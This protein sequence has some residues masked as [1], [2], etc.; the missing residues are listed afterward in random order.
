MPGRHGS[1]SLIGMADMTENQKSPVPIH[2]AILRAAARRMGEGGGFVLLALLMGGAIVLVGSHQSLL[3]MLV[4]V[5]IVTACSLAVLAR[6]QDAQGQ[7]AMKRLM[8][9]AAQTNEELQLRRRF[10]LRDDSDAD[11]VRKDFAVR[12][13]AWHSDA[14]TGGVDMDEVKTARNRLFHLVSARGSAA[15]GAE[16]IAEWSKAAGPLG[17]AWGALLPSDRL[18][19]ASER[20]G[21]ELRPSKTSQGLRVQA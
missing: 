13:K 15:T 8:A 3:S 7:K 2:L 17:R 12:M 4:G 9:P 6:A 21:V 10:G 1:D 19:A 14:G 16:L 20:S 5:S 18:L 11:T